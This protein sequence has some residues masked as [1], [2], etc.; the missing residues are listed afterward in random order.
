MPEG[1]EF[2]AAAIAAGLFSSLLTHPSDTTK[3]RMQSN[4]DVAAAPQ[5][6]SQ[7]STMRTLMAE[8]G[9]GSLYAGLLPRALRLIGEG[10]ADDRHRHPA[11]T[12]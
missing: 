2:A 1:S 11:V 4:L 5:Y 10:I 3:T 6:S 12:H 9:V 7:L 8:K